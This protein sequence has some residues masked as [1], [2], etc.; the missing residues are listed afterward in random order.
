MYLL[1]KIFRSSNSSCVGRIL[2]F[3]IRRAPMASFDSCRSLSLCSCKIFRLMSSWRSG[4]SANFKDRL[5]FRASLFAISAGS[6][7]SRYSTGPSPES[8]FASSLMMYGR[9]FSL[10]S[11]VQGSDIPNFTGRVLN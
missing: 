8:P 9:A 10:F 6:S 7:S 4:R 2:S 1:F 11:N 5:S 3:R